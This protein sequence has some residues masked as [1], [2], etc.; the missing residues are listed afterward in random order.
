MR[1][2]PTGRPCGPGFWKP[3]GWSQGSEAWPCVGCAQPCGL[4]PTSSLAPLSPVGSAPATSLPHGTHRQARRL[5]PCCVGK[6]VFFFELKWGVSSSP[7]EMPPLLF[8]DQEPSVTAL[9]GPRAGSGPPCTFAGKGMSCSVCG[10]GLRA[11]PEPEAPP[12]PVLSSQILAPS[13]LPVICRLY[14]RVSAKQQSSLN[15]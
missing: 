10:L 8:W 5:G 1:R 14:Q 7:H 3:R 13:Q 4:E 2:V 12:H 11:D 9:G 15:L 6:T